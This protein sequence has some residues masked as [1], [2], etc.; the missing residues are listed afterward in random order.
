MIKLSSK[1]DQ[2]CGT[3]NAYKDKTTV[4]FLICL[5]SGCPADYTAL[6]G[7]CYRLL[8]TD[9]D[10]SYDEGST[11]CKNSAGGHLVAIQSEAE[12]FLIGQAFSFMSDKKIYVGSEYHLVMFYLDFFGQLAFSD[13]MVTS[14]LLHQCA[15]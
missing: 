10:F 1:L 5:G 13:T 6:G 3:L 8:F 12:N 14:S 2:V 4:L 7:S 15:H 9:E 11:L